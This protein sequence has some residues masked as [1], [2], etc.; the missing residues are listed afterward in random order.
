MRR[1]LQAVSKHVATGPCP[2]AA[3]HYRTATDSSTGQ[4]KVPT[5]FSTVELELEDL[6]TTGGGAYP[7]TRVISPLMRIPVRQE[8]G[9]DGPARYQEATTYTFLIHSMK[10]PRLTQLDDGR[11]FMIATGWITQHEADPT[12]DERT[13][14]IIESNTEGQSWTQPRVFH[15][16][17]E[18]PEP[19][20]LGSG[21]ILVVPNDDAGFTCSSDDYGAT[22][23]EKVPY[24]HV[25]PDGRESFRHGT[26]LVEDDGQTVSGVFAAM[27]QDGFHQSGWAAQAMIRTSRDGGRTWNEGIF[28]PREWNASEG[29]LTRAQDGALV[30]SLRTDRAPGLPDFCDHWRRLATARS[31]DNGLSW[32]DYQ[33]HFSFGKVHSGLV[34]LRDGRLLMTYAA[35][36]GEVAGEMYHGIVSMR[37]LLGRRQSRAHL[38]SH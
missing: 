28:L 3:G 30:V 2:A 23:T 10:F 24:P 37:E 11:L 27:D 38:L 26:L 18:R 1:R 20:S 32:T 16:G 5:P 15:T 36:I 8:S 6:T 7:P 34:L 33:V 12:V 17:P 22:W 4:D 14:F 19:V 35:R 13:C 9:A 31:M 25:L 29:A 21:R